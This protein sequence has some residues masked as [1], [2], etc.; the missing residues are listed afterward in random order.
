[1]SD[2]LALA[3]ARHASENQMMPNRCGCANAKRMPQPRLLGIMNSMGLAADWGRVTG[4]QEGTEL[5]LVCR[6]ITL[7]T[8]LNRLPTYRTTVRFR[9]PPAGLGQFYILR[10]S[11]SKSNH[12]C[13]LGE[14]FG[15]QGATFS[16]VSM[17]RL[18][19]ED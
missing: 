8:D 10:G 16:R 5:L 9:T 2:P 19:P 18:L 14:T 15:P 4:K 1:M 3:A 7:D 12:S 17:S 13:F 6:P 11:L